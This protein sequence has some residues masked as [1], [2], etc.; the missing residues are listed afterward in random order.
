[1]ALHTKLIGEQTNA[2]L[3]FLSVFGGGLEARFRVW[4]PNLCE[5][6]YCHGVAERKVFFF[7]HPSDLSI[8][9]YT[10]TDLLAYYDIF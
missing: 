10:S 1:M 4:V 3:D 9:P 2:V 7:C 8:S 5:V 6:Y